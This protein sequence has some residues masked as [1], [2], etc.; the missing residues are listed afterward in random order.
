M[1]CFKLFQN[2]SGCFCFF[3][4]HFG[5][6]NFWIV[7]IAS[8]AASPVESVPLPLANLEPK[9]FG[10]EPPSA[11]SAISAVL[12]LRVVGRQAERLE[13]FRFLNPMRSEPSDR[14]IGHPCGPRKAFAVLL[15]HPRWR[16]FLQRGLSEPCCLWGVAS[17]LRSLLEAGHGL[18]RFRAPP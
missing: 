13:V 10:I 15:Q 4:N 16:I 14:R 17:A 11:L 2:E 1:V 8:N 7:P 9:A 12:A 6:E 3:R 5:I 18:W